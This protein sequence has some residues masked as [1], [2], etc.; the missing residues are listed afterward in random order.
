[1]AG[2]GLLIDYEFCTGCH[3]CEVACKKH[4]DLKEGEK[5]INVL[6]DGPRQNPDG[7]WEWNYIPVPSSLCDL[8]A[9]RV[10]AGMQPTCVHHCNSFVIYYGAIEDLAKKMTKPE[11]V[12]FSRATDGAD[13]VGLKG[14]AEETQVEEVVAAP[15]A[16]PETKTE[17]TAEKGGY[18]PPKFD[19]IVWECPECG[20]FNQKTAN[21][22]R[23]CGA[24]KPP[25]QA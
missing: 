14:A 4:L 21:T 10:E 23:K 24:S 16:V 5:G 18:R 12:L 3:A 13:V 19:N 25:K 15:V 9:D 11:M 8:C 1:M 2:Y 20:T 6:S 17:D 22:C 7:R